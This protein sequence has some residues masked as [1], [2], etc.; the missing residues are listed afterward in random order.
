MRKLVK[1]VYP[2]LRWHYRKAE[3]FTDR[4]ILSPKNSDVT[5]I[6]NSV[7]EQLPGQVQEYLSVDTL[8]EQEALQLPPEFLHSINVSGIPVHCLRLKKNTPVLLLRN[9][10]TER[11]LCNGRRLQIID[12][13]PHCL[14]ARILT[15]KRRGD[16]VLL[17]HIFCD[18]NDVNLPFQIRRKQFPVQVCFAMTIN[19][20]QGQSLHHLG[21]YL[22]SDVFAHG[23][24]YVALSRVTS[25]KNVA[26]LI[27]N[28][29][30][31]L[32][33]VTVGNI[34]YHEVIE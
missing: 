33:G 6:N 8:E 7:L 11:G 18:S 34:V 3:Y 32:E 1:R 16:D 13:K 12:M 15:G 5:A 20:E 9:L 27:V 19:T 31:D 17:P 10:N 4:A 25:R 14:H 21:L 24:L 28:P 23:Q 29:D 30:Y 26:V 2:N 22:P